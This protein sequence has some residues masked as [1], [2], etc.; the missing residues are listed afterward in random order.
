MVLNGLAVK[1][2]K[3]P[4]RTSPNLKC[5]VESH[6]VKWSFFLVLKCVRG[7]LFRMTVHFKGLKCAMHSLLGTS[8]LFD[9]G[10]T[11][12]ATASHVVYERNGENR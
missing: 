8:G 1:R 3:L 7:L 9:D 10:K 4:V 5:R 12:E 11:E 2:P 6:Q